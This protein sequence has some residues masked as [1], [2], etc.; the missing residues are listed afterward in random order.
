MNYH[1]SDR[2]RQL[3][4]IIEENWFELGSN[5]SDSLKDIFE[6][7][8]KNAQ[9]G[10]ILNILGFHARIDFVSSLND[11]AQARFPWLPEGFRTNEYTNDLDF[12]VYLVDSLKPLMGVNP[13]NNE[14]ESFQLEIP[15]V[16]YDADTLNMIRNDWHDYP[17]IF[18]T[19]N[20]VR[21]WQEMDYMV[22][23]IWSGMSHQQLLS[24]YFRWGHGSGT[25]YFPD[26]FDF[27]F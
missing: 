27:W 13:V 19:I 3:D 4:R 2:I 26:Y 24:S 1:P 18:I 11:I 14:I 20:Q 9:R 23:R 21:R 6:R 5:P 16:G 22:D 10:S 25:E 15:F 17:P 8:V 12:W 7:E